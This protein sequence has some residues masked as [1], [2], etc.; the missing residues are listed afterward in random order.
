MCW[1]MWHK[2]QYFV[3]L[4][5][6]FPPFCFVFVKFLAP[7]FILFMYMK[8]AFIHTML[9]KPISFNVKYMTPLRSVNSRRKYQKHN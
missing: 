6:L 5:L 2:C 1:D 3:I 8:V 7:A 4:L 9:I